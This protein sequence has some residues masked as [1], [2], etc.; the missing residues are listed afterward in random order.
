MEKT[1]GEKS[2]PQPIFIYLSLGFYSTFINGSDLASRGRVNRDACGL[3]HATAD[4]S[5]AVDKGT[6]IEQSA[7]SATQHPRSNAR[8]GRA[9]STENVGSPQLSRQGCPVV[10]R[11]RRYRKSAPK[12]ARFENTKCRTEETERERRRRSYVTEE[13]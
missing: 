2:L 10:M 7:Q 11:R 1:H 4:S 5:M 6:G 8:I 13:G 3:I 9:K 12:G